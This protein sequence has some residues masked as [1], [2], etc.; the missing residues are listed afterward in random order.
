MTIMTLAEIIRMAEIIRI[1]IMTLADM[2][3]MTIMKLED[4]IRMT[5]MIVRIETSCISSFLA[6][7][8]YSV[9]TW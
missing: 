1:A 3:R 2:I 5:I 4:M 9:S 7:P 6:M 8:M